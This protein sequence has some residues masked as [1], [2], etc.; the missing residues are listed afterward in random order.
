MPLLNPVHGDAD[1]HRPSSETRVFGRLGSE[2][3]L[4]AIC[5]TLKTHSTMGDVTVHG[6]RR[7]RQRWARG[8][9]RAISAMKVSRREARKSARREI[10]KRPPDSVHMSLTAVKQVSPHIEFIGIDIA[11]AAEVVVS[12]RAVSPSVTPPEASLDSAVGMVAM[13]GMS[14]IVGIDATNASTTHVRPN[15]SATAAQKPSRDRRA[16][17]STMGV[18]TR[19]RYPGH[20]HVAR[21]ECAVA[22]SSSATG[23]GPLG[24]CWTS[25]QVVSLPTTCAAAQHEQ[26][27]GGTDK[28]CTPGIEDPRDAGRL[29]NARG[30][31]LSAHDLRRRD[32]EQRLSLNPPMFLAVRACRNARMPSCCRRIGTA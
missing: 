4:R 31:G 25:C 20:L 23:S 26:R 5:H 13:P 27:C 14:L 9:M 24:P 11:D 1:Q 6:V 32:Q 8:R 16:N 15:A 28:L 2:R 10:V 3:L 18:V 12:W 19:E 7:C 30:G 17:P 22:H 21:P 29:T